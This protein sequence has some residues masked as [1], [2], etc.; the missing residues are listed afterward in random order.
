MAYLG[1]MPPGRVDFWADLVVAPA[2]NWWDEQK[3]KELVPE[4]PRVF[5]RAVADWAKL[6]VGTKA[7]LFTVNQQAEALSWFRNFPKLWETIRPNFITTNVGRTWS[8]TVDDFV[9]RLKGEK[10]WRSTELGLAPAV[11]AGVLIVG[12]V[13]ASLWAVNY[14]LEQRNLSAMIDGVTAGRIPPDVLAKAI[15]AEKSGGLFGGLTDFAKWALMGGIG[16]LLIPR[17]WKK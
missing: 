4:F 10:L 15:E 2:L 7:G 6:K 16:L 11:I 14:I 3:V 8:Q 17:I 12:G 13:A 5:D 9:V 1:Q